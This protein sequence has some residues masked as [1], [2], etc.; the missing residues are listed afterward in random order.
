MRSKGRSE[1]VPDEA[2]AATPTGFT[3]TLPSP[4]SVLVTVIVTVSP[5]TTAPATS[6][7]P[8]VSTWY[9]LL[10]GAMP[11][12]KVTLNVAEVPGATPSAWNKTRPSGNSIPSGLPAWFN[13]EQVSEIAMDLRMV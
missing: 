5:A 8:P 9:T 12:G 3:M 7:N 6:W 13:R 1:P 10:P 4:A 2:G 11:L